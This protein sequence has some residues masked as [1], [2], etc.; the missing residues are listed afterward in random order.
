MAKPAHPLLR[1]LVTGIAEMGLASI[2][3]LL[4]WCAIFGW[5]GELLSGNDAFLETY[6]IEHLQAAGGDWSQ[7]PYDHRVM[8]G[9]AAHSTYGSVWLYRWGVQ[10]GLSPQGTYNF[11]LLTLQVLM[12]LL[13]LWILRVALALAPKPGPA[14]QANER[15]RLRICI[16]ALSFLIFAFLPWWGWRVGYGHAIH[17]FGFIALPASLYLLLAMRFGQAQLWPSLWAIIALGIALSSAGAQ[18]LFYALT[19]L[20][21]LAVLMARGT[22]RRAVGTLLLLAFGV[23]AW[24]W[25]SGVE[26]VSHYVMGATAR[27]DAN[28]PVIYSYLPHA[29]SEWLKSLT[30]LDMQ[31]AG[32][33]QPQNFWHEVDLAWGLW[34]LAAAAAWRW[35]PLRVALLTYALLGLGIAAIVYQWSP[36]SE[37]LLA[38]CRALS[39]PVESFRVPSRWIWVWGYPVQILAWSVILHR[40]LSLPTQKIEGRIRGLAA[41][42][43]VML[44]MLLLSLGGWWKEVAV[45]LSL[46]IALD[47]LPLQFTADKFRLSREQAD[48]L[49]RFTSSLELRLVSLLALLVMQL[50]AFS[51]RLLPMSDLSELQSF[52]ERSQIAQ[53]LSSTDRMTLNPLLPGFGAQS[54][55]ALGGAGI[56]GNWI[57]PK[58]FLKLL[59]ALE[60]VP[61][62][63]AAVIWSFRPSH[64]FA[65]WLREVFHVHRHLEMTSSGPSWSG[66][67]RPSMLK[68]A[69]QA[70]VLNSWEQWP[71][72]ARRSESARDT[73]WI[74]PE[75]RMEWENLQLDSTPPTRALPAPCLKTQVSDERLNWTGSLLYEAQ[76]EAA[77]PLNS[78]VAILPLGYHAQLRAMWTNDRGEQVEL[79]TLRAQA[80]LTAVIWPPRILQ[81]EA[82]SRGRLTIH[83]RHMLSPGPS[84]IV[85]LAGWILVISGLFLIARGKFHR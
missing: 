40:L 18:I 22:P 74:L 48:R 49:Q 75:D 47:L 29:A 10:L 79:K 67:S 28:S 72:L 1:Q 46:V 66:E 77:T 57:M 82:P 35:R 83:W 68:F 32:V 50:A 39:L 37:A 12:G 14:T 21:V 25:P 54:I 51:D 23:L 15:S 58:N 38:I 85:I 60:G 41:L 7:R 55:P 2:A 24:A 33:Q 59:A 26:V 16:E 30:W 84:L 63:A 3:I 20:A 45:A 71:E 27:G 8:G 5:R 65:P 31:E 70:E 44:L 17:L 78:C 52:R 43:L 9:V 69:A 4:V 73:L 34:F 42:I 76:L 81:A 13:S 11:A 80:A 6:L 62:P 19:I 53:Q 64:A 36:I 56:D 61:A